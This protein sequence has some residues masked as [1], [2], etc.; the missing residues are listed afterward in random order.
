[1]KAPAYIA[2]ALVAAAAGYAFFQ[3]GVRQ[4]VMDTQ[5]SP[6]TEATESEAAIPEVLPD[7]TLADI[8]GQQHRQ[9][10]S[11]STSPA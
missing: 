8:D 4:Q 10:P 2:I 11:S 6:V 5:L 9:G 1:M 7:F 3:F